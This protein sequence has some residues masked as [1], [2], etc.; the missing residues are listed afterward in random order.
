MNDILAKHT[1]QP[2][3]KIAQDTERDYFM[4]GEE[5][6]SYGLIDEV[7]VRS[8]EKSSKDGSKS[9]GKLSVKDKEGDD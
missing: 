2:L 1:G 5:A 6:K 9:G 3:E 4:S 8:P 7:I